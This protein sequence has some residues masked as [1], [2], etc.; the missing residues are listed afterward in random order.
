MEH[1]TSRGP[2]DVSRVTKQRRDQEF[3]SSPENGRPKNVTVL[4]VPVVLCSGGSLGLRQAPGDRNRRRDTS[5][6]HRSV[7]GGVVHRDGSDRSGA[8]RHP[9]PH[10]P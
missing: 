7:C 5:G 10:L 3:P 4:L 8:C 1:G 9:V 2:S 6:R